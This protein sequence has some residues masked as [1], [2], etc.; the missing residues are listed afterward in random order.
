MKTRIRTAGELHEYV[1]SKQILLKK[2]FEKFTENEIA[3]EKSLDGVRENETTMKLRDQ[4][5]TF[6]RKRLLKG[7]EF[8]GVD[9]KKLKA[10][11]KPSLHQGLRR[12]PAMHNQ[13]KGIYEKW[14]KFGTPKYC[15]DNENGSTSQLT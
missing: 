4:I 12:D 13:V 2:Q 9:A 14:Q 8:K 6:L 7:Q 1:D 10:Q 11:V 5:G 15:N 3:K